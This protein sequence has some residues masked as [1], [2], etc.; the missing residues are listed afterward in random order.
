[1][2]WGIKEEGPGT[3]EAGFFKKSNSEGAAQGGRFFR[4]F[5]ETE[6]G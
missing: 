3:V 4:E 5:A 2:V 6:G 1:M